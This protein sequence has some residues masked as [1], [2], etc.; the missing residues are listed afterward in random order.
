M[1]LSEEKTEDSRDERN[2]ILGVWFNFHVVVFS[3]YIFA[4]D[5]EEEEEE[6]ELSVDSVSS[7]REHCL[8]VRRTT[9]TNQPPSEGEDEKVEQQ[10]NEL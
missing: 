8:P 2:K 9:T 7:T 6:V 3:F 5:E 10:F 4:L 1:C